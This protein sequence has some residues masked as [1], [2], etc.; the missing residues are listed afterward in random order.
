MRT[1]KNLAVPQNSD[2]KFPF[3]TIQNETDVLDGTPVVEEIYGDVLTNL[4]KLLQVVA[5]KVK[6]CSISFKEF[7][8]FFSASNN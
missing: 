4:Y 1:I 5:V 7:G 6:T 2:P 3:S 8:S